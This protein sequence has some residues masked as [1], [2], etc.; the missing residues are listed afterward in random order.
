MAFRFNTLPELYA[1][2]FD[3]VIDVRS[4]AEFAED[5]VP[6]AINLPVLSNE[7][8]A[9]VG[10]IYVQDA[11][12]KARKIGAALVAR[13][14]ARHIEGPLRDKDGG[15][16]PLVYCWRGGQRSGSFA[17]ILSQIGWRVDLIEGG[18]QTYRRA[19]KSVLYDLPFEPP[20]ILLDGNTGTAKTDI[21]ELL[22][23]R[24]VQALDLEGL[25]NHR[26]SVFGGMG[27]QPEQKGFETALAREMVA[28]DP[29]RP[30]VVEAESSK[31]GARIVP[32]SLWK[33]MRDAPRIEIAAPVAA[34]VRYLVSAY[35]DIIRDRETLTRVVASLKRLQGRERVEHW[36]GLV[37]REDFASLAEELVIHHYDPRYT[38]QRGDDNRWLGRVETETLD[39]DALERAADR[40]AA[41]VAER[42]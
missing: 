20:V 37:E 12:F 41:I 15:W 40:V 22:K 32:P 6:G 3:T 1:H 7:E 4:P 21:L 29:S 24:G 23:A 17:A 18:Y 35:D 9:E 38:R 33:A 39:P 13:N 31:V 14:A 25:A 16:R 11:P 36:Q 28:L 26:G 5:H 30:V 42:R 10:T 19:V 27:E 34:R 2:G 8:R